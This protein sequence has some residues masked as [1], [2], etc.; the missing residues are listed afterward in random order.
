MSTTQRYIG[1]NDQVV[2][3]AEGTHSTR[4]SF[5]FLS[6]SAAKS[7]TPL[8]RFKFFIKSLN[9]SRL[10]R[11]FEQIK[12]ETAIGALPCN[13]FRYFDLF[14]SIVACRSH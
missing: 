2:K 4:I 3:P 12:Q 1:L 6:G 9:C 5:I 10:Y 11:A 14:T 7:F 8:C 13:A